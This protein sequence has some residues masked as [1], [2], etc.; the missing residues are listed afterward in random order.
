M[1]KSLSSP[2]TPSRGSPGFFSGKK[3]RH[4]T[5]PEASSSRPISGV[6]Y[7]STD[8][9]TTDVSVPLILL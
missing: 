6:S 4:S 7:L 3:K 8:F 2:R 9:D 5:T 1:S